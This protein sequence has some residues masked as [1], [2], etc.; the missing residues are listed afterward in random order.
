MPSHGS[1]LGRLVQHE[2]LAAIEALTAPDDVHT[3]VHEARKAIRRARS[4]LALVEDELDV[5]AADVILQRA[6]E[7][8]GPLRDAHAV[9]LTVIRLAKRLPDPHWQQAVGALGARA[10]RLARRELAADPGL[11]KRRRAIRRAA[12]LLDALPWDTLK[13]ADIRDGLVRQSRRADKAAKRAKKTPEPE[14]LHRWRRRVRR[15]RMQ[16]DALAGLKL[17]ILDQDPAVS[18]RLHQ[19]SDELGI[20][21]DLEVLEDVLKRMRSLE[22]RHA[23][24]AQLGNAEVRAAAH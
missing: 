4:L 13:S 7:S 5:G 19:L 16:V 3:H 6:G 9:H 18:K 15:L 8:L 22:C 21:Q 14:N 17:S 23:L 12:R 11:A 24:V 20:H 1:R 2:G 10:D